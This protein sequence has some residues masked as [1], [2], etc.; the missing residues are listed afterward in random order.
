MAAMSHRPEPTDF[1]DDA[2]PAG[3]SPVE[4]ARLVL[5]AALRRGWSAL[6]VFLAGMAAATAYYA[7][8]K[9]TYS[10][11]TRILVQRQQAL[12]TAVRSAFEDMPTRSASDMI[13]RRDNLISLVQQA[14][15]APESPAAPPPPSWHDRLTPRWLRDDR[16]PGDPLDA[17]VDLLGRR[18]EVQ[19][20]DN[21]ITI[22][23]EWGD[24][25][26]P[27]RIV[28][29]ALDNFLEA[30]HLQEVKAGD[31]VIA[32]LAARTS[33]LRQ[34]LDAAIEDARRRTSSPRAAA[35]RVRQPSEE[36]VRLQS[37]FDA[38]QRAL[39]DVEDQRRR[40][41]ADLQAQLDQARNT[42]SEAHPTVISLRKD[43]EALSVDSPQVTALREEERAARRAYNDRLAREGVTPGAVVAAVAPTPVI[44]PTGLATEDPQ[45]RDLRVQYESIANRLNAAQ[46]ELDAARAAFKYRYS[47]VWPPQLPTDPVSPNPR[48][49]FGLGLLAALA[50]GVLAA[51]APD[52]RSGRILERW[53]VER[54]LGVPVVGEIRRGA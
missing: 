44:D 45:V 24:P 28:R 30:R 52:L 37:L 53:Q 23:L 41:L 36:L 3:P 31:E 19:V 5:R 32:V 9:P 43:I 26:T 49:I 10:V 39:R 13:H 21:A 27:F 12:P 48:K 20:Q 33:T 35:P 34:Q 1:D 14:N 6:A 22:S 8:K 47:V 15:L 11:E 29:A 42:M 18:L 4:W 16:P 17:M 40:R 46:V 7:T 54:S 2:S 51:A 50:L 25:Q 38:R